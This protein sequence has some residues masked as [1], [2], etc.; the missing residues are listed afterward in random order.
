MGGALG[1]RG[2]VDGREVEELVR[3]ESLD[4][5]FALLLVSSRW[6]VLIGRGG[7]VAALTVQIQV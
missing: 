6:V 5:G 1:R 7:A 4:R 3:F 2:L